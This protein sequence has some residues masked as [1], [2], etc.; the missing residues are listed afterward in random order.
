MKKSTKDRL[1]LS[2]GVFPTVIAVIFVYL[3]VT[4]HISMY[5]L[6]DGALP[7]QTNI[8]FAIYKWVA[9]L[10][11]VVIAVW[12][13]WKNRPHR[14]KVTVGFGFLVSVL[15][16]GVVVW[17]SFQPDIIMTIIKNGYESP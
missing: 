2:L 8:V 5:S 9:I 3:T 14:A 10:P 12:Y 4:T 1:L 17:A 15:I 11:L 13:F 6:Y 7:K 16:S